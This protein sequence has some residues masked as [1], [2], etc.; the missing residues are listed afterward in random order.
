MSG[1]S[2]KN[3]LVLNSSLYEEIYR[4]F[5]ITLPPIGAE[6]QWFIPFKSRRRSQW[7]RLQSQ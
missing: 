2:S 6:Y 1:T 7:H 4:L 3:L 5:N